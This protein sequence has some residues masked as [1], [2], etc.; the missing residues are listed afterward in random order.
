VFI[1]PALFSFEVIKFNFVTPDAFNDE[2]HV[3]GLLDDENEEE[4][5]T[6]NEP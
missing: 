1:V 4:L 2:Q 3:I 6:F 5:L